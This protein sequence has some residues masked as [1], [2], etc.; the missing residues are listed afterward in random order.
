LKPTRVPAIRCRVLSGP[1]SVKKELV[2][3]YNFGLMER[4]ME[5]AIAIR[6]IRTGSSTM[7]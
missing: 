2:V 3:G 7:G 1:Q 4:R 6:K 5:N